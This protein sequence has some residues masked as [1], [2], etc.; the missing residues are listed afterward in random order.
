MTNLQTRFFGLKLQNPIIIASSGLTAEI[1][2]IKQFS[3]LG[4]GAIVLKSVYEEEVINEY[5]PVSY[6]HLTLPTKRIV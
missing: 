5:N 2:N 1:K 6:T 4:A 3:E